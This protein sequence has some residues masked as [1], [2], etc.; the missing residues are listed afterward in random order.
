VVVVG[1]K[2]RLVVNRSIADSKPVVGLTDIHLHFTEDTRL[3][4]RPQRGTFAMI[5][6]E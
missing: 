4:P 1:G 2:N 5:G 3:K 6:N